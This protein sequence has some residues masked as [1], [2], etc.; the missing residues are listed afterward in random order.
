MDAVIFEPSS[1]KEITC[2]CGARYFIRWR[3]PHGPMVAGS[4]EFRCEQ[5]GEVF[6]LENLP[7]SRIQFELLDT[8]K[9]KT[10]DRDESK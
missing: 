6:L 1:G 4:F 2:P 8:G 10:S 7:A 3:I 9:N 5:C